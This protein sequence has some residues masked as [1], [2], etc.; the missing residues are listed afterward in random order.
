MQFR[1][2]FEKNDSFIAKILMLW[3]CAGMLVILPNNG[4]SGLSLPQNLLAWSYM[5]LLFMILSMYKKNNCNYNINTISVLLTIL[6]G[7]CL[8]ALPLLWTREL[9]WFF[10]AIPRVL[11]IIALLILFNKLRFFLNSE[12]SRLQL[13]CVIITSALLQS[14]YAIYQLATIQELPGARPYG[15]FQ[16]VNV[17]A[18]WLS[19]GICCAA[20]VYSRT[21]FRSHCRNVSTFSLARKLSGISLFILSAMIVL[22]QSRAGYLGALFSLILIFIVQGYHGHLR[23]V[24]GAGLLVSAGISTGI[25]WLNFGYLILPEI[26]FPVI[27]KSGSTTSRIYMLMVTWK[28]IVMH[29]VVGNGYGSFEAIFG[30][31]A[32]DIAPGLEADTVTHPHNELLLAWAEGGI[33]GVCGLLI[34]IAGAIRY[35]WLPTGMALSGVALLMPVAIHSNLEYP[36]YQSASHGLLMIT[37]LCIAGPLSK[38]FKPLKIDHEGLSTKIIRSCSKI[39]ALLSG[40]FVLGFMITGVITQHNLTKIE[41]QGLTPFAFNEEK[42]LETLPNPLS[43]Q[44]RMDFDRHVALLLRYNMTQDAE[45]LTRFTAWGTDYLKTHNDP[46]VYDSL[47]R[48]A[49]A[50]NNPEK[51]RLC[52]EA[53]GRWPS[54]LRFNCNQ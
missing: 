26:T 32:R 50:K 20:L 22:I 30:Q 5:S 18:S 52:L 9:D 23:Q 53:H 21:T 13:L 45:L 25:L 29:P 49:R 51:Y 12:K 4:G 37:L 34:M 41:R 54:D 40:L 28:M 46:S 16:Q 24:L 2:L 33:V 43:Q 27:P 48:I 6:A 14:A 7:W 35:I 15:S 42:V 47:L 10:N 3:F 19:T 44:T 38:N 17:L 31:L 36:L 39:A 1:F 8:W 11:T